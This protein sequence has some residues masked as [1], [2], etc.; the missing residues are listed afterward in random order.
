MAMAPRDA[1]CSLHHC[2][3]SNVI[4]VDRIEIHQRHERDLRR[5]ALD[6]KHRLAGE[7]SVDP[8]AVQASRKTAAAIERLD[9]VGPAKLVQPRIGL[10]DLVGDPAALTRRVGAAL[11]HARKAGIHANL[12]AL[13]ALPHRARHAQAIEWQDAARIRRPPAK[14]PCQLRDAHRE[15]ATPIRVNHRRRFEIGLQFHE[16]AFGPP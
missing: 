4:P 3:S 15:Q 1:R 16:I 7:E 14:Q 12:V 5:V 10:D 11:H 8:D 6:V 2:T 9:A 13:R